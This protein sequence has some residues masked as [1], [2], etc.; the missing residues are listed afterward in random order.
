MGANG[1]RLPLAVGLAIAAASAATLALRPRSGLMEP[2][3]VDAEGYFSEEEIGRARRYQ[4]P[5]R[6]LGLLALGVE[7]G[8]LA[9]VTLQPPKALQRAESRPI[10]GAA[11]VGAGL[12]AGLTALGLPL[13]AVNHRRA[14][15][16]GISVQ[17]WGGWLGD[18]GKA[19]AIETGMAAAGSAGA[20]VGICPLPGKSVGAGFGGGLAPHA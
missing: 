16:A 11:A 1:Y 6:A 13:N 17:S 5:R 15:D 4:R 7:G 8:A 20:G 19:T 14:V 3:P 9:L 2:A 18:V 12:S 10:A